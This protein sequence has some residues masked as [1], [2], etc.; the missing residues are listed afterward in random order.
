MASPLRPT[1][2]RLVNRRIALG[3]LAA[4]TLINLFNYLDRYVVAALLPSLGRA[5]MGLTDYRL[6]TLM[7][8]FLIVYMVAA[9]VFGALGDRGS[10]TKSIAAGVLVWSFATALSGLARSY[11]QLLGAR[12]VVGI[13]EAAY[14]TIAP[15]ML[16]DYFAR[17]ERGR[18][19][20]VFN[21][22]IPVGAACGYVVGG[23]MD[24]AYGWRAA[25]LVAGL[26]G[27]ALAAWLLRLP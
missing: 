2:D 4:L 14:A 18:V 17:S 24:H 3:A 6:G 22:A 11:F 25:F 12:A 16:A 5:H 9:P 19:L 8:S 1:G 15:S 23:L 26:P 20:A 7:S 10:R 27:I 13:G 21:M